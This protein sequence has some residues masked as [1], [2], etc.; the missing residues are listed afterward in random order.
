MSHWLFFIFFYKAG[1]LCWKFFLEETYDGGINMCQG[2][3][4]QKCRMG[5]AAG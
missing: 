4:K 2:L 5:A 3:V 1:R